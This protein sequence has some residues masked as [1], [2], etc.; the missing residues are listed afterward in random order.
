MHKANHKDLII[1]ILCLLIGFA[2]RYYTLDRKSLWLDEIYTHNEAR[3]GLKDQLNFYQEKPYN[4][5]SP[6]FFILS[7][8]FYPTTKPERDL[9]IIPLIFGTL[10]IPMIYLLSRLFSGKI[11]LPC[12][13]TVT[14][15]AYHISIS[16]EGRSYSMLMFLG[17]VGVYFFLKH[18]QT[19]KKQYL[20]PGAIL[21]ATMFYIS[22]SSIPF[23]VF[24]QILWFYQ[25]HEDNKKFKSFFL[26]NFQRFDPFLLPPLDPFFGLKL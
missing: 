20:F 26:V 23:I 21:Y 4:I 7:N 18:L 5:Q 19:S 14:L 16:Q 22:Y 9:R 1:V 17:M 8:L 15:M 3:Y 6:F 13:F 2:L 11:A 25:I 24:S 10:S 12:M